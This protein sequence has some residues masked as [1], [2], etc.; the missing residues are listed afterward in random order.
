MDWIKLAREIGFEDAC[1]LNMEALKPMK[2]VREM[3]SANRCRAYG[4]SWACPPGCGSIE[5]CESRIKGY[6]SGVLV[7][8]T[9]ILDDVF[10][11]EGMEKAMQLHR[12]RFE[13]LARQARSL[14]GDCLP[15]SAGTCTRCEVC[16]YPDSPC[17]FPDEALSSME[18]FG[19]LVSQVCSD[20]GMTYYK[21][22]KT[23]TYTSCLLFKIKEKST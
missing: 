2:E 3:C 8:T 18:A 16:T 13:E 6:D 11:G 20:S 7:Q 19:L 10:D 15:L 22:E 5:Q 9:G 17:R 21:G 23:I 12:R 1:M 14:V 4:K